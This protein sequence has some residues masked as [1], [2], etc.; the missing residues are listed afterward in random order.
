MQ[1]EA[2]QVGVGQGRDGATVASRTIAELVLDQRTRHAKRRLE[3]IAAYR[4]ALGNDEI[5]PVLEA[6]IAR[7]AELA[8]AVEKANASFLA[9]DKGTSVNDVVRAQRAHSLVE[10]S[11]RLNE[12]TAKDGAPNL[13]QYLATRG[14]AA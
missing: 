12:K 2:P 10:K 13:A 9:G 7:C 3:L 1:S 14:E 6:R 8:V 11:L 4:V 5:S